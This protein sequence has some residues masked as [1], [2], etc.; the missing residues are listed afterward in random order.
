V[1]VELI[2]A[3]FVCL[4]RDAVRETHAG[5]LRFAFWKDAVKSSAVGLNVYPLKPLTL[6]PHHMH[7]LRPTNFACS[8]TQAAPHQG[9]RHATRFTGGHVSASCRG[10]CAAGNATAQANPAVPWA[11][12]RCARSRHA[13]GPIRHDPGGHLSDDV[14]T[15]LLTVS[16]RR[17]VDAAFLVADSHSP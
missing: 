9:Y 16:L 15:I 1:V 6:H 7:S 5:H 13:T 3:A 11:D 8:F 4:Y 2:P 10:S 17:L 14:A 12:G